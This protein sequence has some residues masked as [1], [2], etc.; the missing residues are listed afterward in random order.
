M[1]EQDINY[2]HGKIKPPRSFLMGYIRL[3]KTQK[4]NIDKI[5]WNSIRHPPR[6][7]FRN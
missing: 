1:A 2:T 3:I 4:E 5:L 6:K 7:E